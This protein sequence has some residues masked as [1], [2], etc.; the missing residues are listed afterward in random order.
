MFILFVLFFCIQHLK[1]V[2]CYFFSVFKKCGFFNLFFSF[3]TNCVCGVCVYTTKSLNAMMCPW[4]DPCLSC[5]MTSPVCLVLLTFC[6]HQYW[7]HAVFFFNILKID[8]QNIILLFFWRYYPSSLFV[9]QNYF[10]SMFFFTFWDIFKIIVIIFYLFKTF[11]YTNFL[12]KCFCFFLYIYFV[13]I[14]YNWLLI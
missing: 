12:R 3:C 11:Q 1:N 6:I 13:K 9:F 10:F 5:V 4:H 14:I 2:F 8:F 7:L